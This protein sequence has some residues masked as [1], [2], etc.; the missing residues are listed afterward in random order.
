MSNSTNNAESNLTSLLPTVPYT[1]AYTLPLLLLSTLLIFSG[2]FLTLDRTR[3]F[4]PKAGRPDYSAVGGLELK[5]KKRRFSL[6][7]GGGVGGIAIGYTFGVHLSTLLALLIPGKTSAAAL[8]PNS[9]LAVWILCTLLTMFLGGRYRSAA[10]LFAGLEGGAI[11]ALGLSVILH[12]SLLPRLILFCISTLLLTLLIGASALIPRLTATLLHPVLRVCTSA[13]GSFGLVVSIALLS[14]PRIDGWA[15]VYER[16]WVH[17][18][19][20]WGG[21]KEKGLSAAWGIMWILGIAADWALRRYLGECSDE[22]WDD[23]LTKYIADLPNQKHRA[24]TFQPLTSIWDRLFGAPQSNHDL[25]KD[26]DIIFPSDKDMQRP[27]STPSPF[28]VQPFMDG[29]RPLQRHSSISKV[30]LMYEDEVPS[31]KVCLTKSRSQKTQSRPKP[32]STPRSRKPIKFGAIDELSSDSDDETLPIKVVQ[33]QRPWVITN[34]HSSY[35]SSTQTLVAAQRASEHATPEIEVAKLDYDKEIAELKAARGDKFQETPTY[36]S[37]HEADNRTCDGD[38]ALQRPTMTAPHPPYLSNS[39]THAE[40][41]TPAFMQRH[42]H[43][44]PSPTR[45]DDQAGAT[46][47][48][49]VA[50]LSPPGVLPIPATPS[51]IRAVDRIQQAQRELY[52]QPH[53]V[54][55]SGHDATPAFKDDDAYQDKWRGHASDDLRVEDGRRHLHHHGGH[56][57]RWEDFWREVRTKAQTGFFKPFKSPN[58]FFTLYS[59]FPNLSPRYLAMPSPY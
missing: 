23:Y 58:P 56:S 18:G 45:A 25:F 26:K 28:N 40:N 16:L 5:P 38:I 12:P 13:I 43:H 17:N 53:N 19:D 46:A 24:G 51:L 22:K 1:L 37:D 29:P 2:A 6:F 48:S 11:V 47:L 42:R 33:S 55:P 57:P 20:L 8:S 4:A 31:A 32:K 39:P 14:N 21:G 44:T 52:A 30:P 10:L 36:D 34:Q 35:A 59:P 7:L 49:G 54:T 15:N 41:W 3:S 9:F 50:A 27:I